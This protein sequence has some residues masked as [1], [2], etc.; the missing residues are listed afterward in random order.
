MRFS[1]IALLICMTA[2][3]FVLIILGNWQ[4]ERLAWKEALIERVNARVGLEPV[5]LM[6]LLEGNVSAED[7]EYTPVT[8][9]GTFETG[10]DVFYFTTGNGGASGWDVYT[11]LILDS[12]EVLIVN[13]GF[14]LFP[15]KEEWS[16]AN[17]VARDI[18]SITGLLRFS[19]A[20]KPSASHENNLLKREFYWRSLEEMS[21]SMAYGKDEILPVFV[22]ADDTP[23][24]GGWPKGGSTVISFTNNHLQY[25]LTWYGL[26]ATLVGVGGFFLFSRRQKYDAKE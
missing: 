10:K 3:L 17:L 18:T 26:A 6:S 11:P 14:I 13:R 8:V 22:D 9:E 16:D 21:A 20:E 23:N 19:A 5:S 1:T 4:V 12:G 7:D 15:M 25:A 2:A 24:P